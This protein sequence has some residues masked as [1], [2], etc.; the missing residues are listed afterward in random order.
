[1]SEKGENSVADGNNMGRTLLEY[2]LA[3]YAKGQGHE[4]KSTSFHSA[5]L[6]E[7]TLDTEINMNMKMFVGVLFAMATKAQVATQ[8]WCDA[9][10]RK[11]DA[12]GTT[13][14]P[15]IFFPLY[16]LM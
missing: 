1:M 4:K 6:K 13:A 12:S 9:R 15:W 16:S 10:E 5:Y 14:E 11:H 3:I 8:G 7:I 2:N